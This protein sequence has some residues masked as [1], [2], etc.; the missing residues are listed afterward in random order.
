MFL[1]IYVC[2]HQLLTWFWLL[3]LILIVVPADW[4]TRAADHSV[5]ISSTV[6]VTNAVT[7][8]TNTADTAHNAAA[9]AGPDASTVEHDAHPVAASAASTTAATS[10]AGVPTSHQLQRG[11]PNRAGKSCLPL[12]NGAILNGYRVES[13]H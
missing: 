4:S 13:C 3:F 6:A 7:A 11:S 2:Y 9:G 12:F 10:P 5:T 1:Q 8:D